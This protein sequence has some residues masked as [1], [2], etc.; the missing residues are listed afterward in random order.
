MADQIKRCEIALA[1]NGGWVVTTPDD[2]F[3]AGLVLAAVA[4]KAGLMAW[5]DENLDGDAT[6]VRV[7]AGQEA[8]RRDPENVSK[9]GRE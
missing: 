2:G 3:G 5:L 9:V 6:L 7:A 8:A 1:P 4:S